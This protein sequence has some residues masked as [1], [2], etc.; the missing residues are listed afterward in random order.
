MP[1]NP[2]KWEVPLSTLVPEYEIQ[3]EGIAIRITGNDV[4]SKKP[5]ILH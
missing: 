1:P 2:G 5:G 3:V 4:E